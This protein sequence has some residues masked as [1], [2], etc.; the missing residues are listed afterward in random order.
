MKVCFRMM[1]LFDSGWKFQVQTGSTAVRV[2]GH[3]TIVTPGSL[4]Y[5]P[6]QSTIRKEILQNHHRFAWF[7]PPQNGVPFNDLDFYVGVEFF[8]AP[9]SFAILPIKEYPMRNRHT[10]FFLLARLPHFEDPAWK[11]PWRIYIYKLYTYIWICVYYI[12]MY[13]EFCRSTIKLLSVQSAAYIPVCL[14]HTVEIFNTANMMP[15]VVLQQTEQHKQPERWGAGQRCLKRIKPS[16]IWVSYKKRHASDSTSTKTPSNTQVMVIVVELLWVEY[17]LFATISIPVVI[18]FP[19][20][21]ARSTFLLISIRHSDQCVRRCSMSRTNDGTSTNKHLEL[22]NHLQVKTFTPQK[23]NMSPKEGPF[24][25]KVSSSNHWFS[26]MFKGYR[27]V[28]CVPVH[29]KN[30]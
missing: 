24:Q 6:K 17:L 10:S 13:V 18:H 7:D 30:I 2:S 27:L 8:G 12:Y 20:H 15:I 29:L 3:C 28:F 1:F 11:Q 19:W 9:W 23:I 21:V 25:R 5:Q 16:K 22:M 14:H 26:N 4:Y